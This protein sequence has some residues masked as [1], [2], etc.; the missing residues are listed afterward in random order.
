MVNGESKHTSLSV[1]E[2]NRLTLNGVSNIESFE[3]SYVT[4]EIGDSRVFVEGTGLR[5][6]S[7]N[8][9][10]GEIQIT[11]RIDGVYYG[12]KNKLAGKFRGLFG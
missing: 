5:I 12:E 7:L 3:A 6:E 4:L 9:E 10:N 8:K 1:N 11:G 2:R